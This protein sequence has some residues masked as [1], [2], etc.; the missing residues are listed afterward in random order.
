[1]SQQ[2][3]VRPRL[4]ARH[5][6]RRSLVPFIFTLLAIEFL[7][8]LADGSRQT[9]WP[10]VRRDLALTYTEIGLLLTVP[11][12]AGNLIEPALGILGDVWRRRPL[13]LAGGLCFTLSLLSVALSPSFL[14]LLL[15]YILF[16]PASGAFVNLSQAALMDDDPSRREQNMARWAFAGSLGILAGSLGLGAAVSSGL[17]WR[18]WFGAL[19]FVSLALV[20]A[21]R[22]HPMTTPAHDNEPA[23]ETRT[24][25]VGLKEGMRDALRA[26]RQREVLRWLVL[27]E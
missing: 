17:G 14:P 24:T 25:W 3:T 23:A 1:M 22:R 12:L 9:A 11:T 16:S 13:V 15:A 5:W 10:L 19:A 21:V 20:W 7:D 18:G 6:G 27:L 2:D 26:L 8:E 4:R